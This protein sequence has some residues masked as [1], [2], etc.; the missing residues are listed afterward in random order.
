MIQDDDKRVVTQFFDAFSRGSID[1]AFALM[2]D[3]ATH[4]LIRLKAGKLIEVEE[5]MDT[6]HL[7]DL[8]AAKV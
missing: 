4:F 3:S 1:E 7:H 6:L 5:C 2:S 8:I